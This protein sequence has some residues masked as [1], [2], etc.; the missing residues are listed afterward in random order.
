M[1]SETVTFIANIALALSAIIALVFG[2]VQVR[3]A[4]QE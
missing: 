2:I 3:S 1:T 4:I